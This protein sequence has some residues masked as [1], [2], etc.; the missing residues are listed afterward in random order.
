[1]SYPNFSEPCEGSPDI[2]P[3]ISASDGSPMYD[4]GWCRL[5]QSIIAANDVS[6][7]HRYTE[8]YGKSFFGPGAEVHEWNHDEW[9]PFHLAAENG[10]VDALH[11]LAEIYQFD[12]SQTEPLEARLRRKNIELLNIA[13]L[14]VRFET[15]RRNIS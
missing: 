7:L 10:S 3:V 14:Y 5:V 1:M 2:P 6:N 8:V 4:D 9:D 13:C 15:R 12:P 11:V